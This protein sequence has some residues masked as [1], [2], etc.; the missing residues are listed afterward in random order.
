MTTNSPNIKKRL[1]LPRSE[2]LLAVAVALG[3][4]HHLDHVLRFDHSG[5][6]FKSEITPLTFS[7]LVYPLL[8]SAYLARSH[9]WYRVGAVAVVYIFTQLAHILIETPTD[10]YHTWACGT[11]NAAETLGHPNLLG[12][13]SPAIGAYAVILSILLSVALILTLIGFIRDALLARKQ[14]A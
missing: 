3:L 13:A 14:T 10:Q 11:S 9:P 2:V 8:L 4:L 7:L 5:W 12:I 1:T 6:P